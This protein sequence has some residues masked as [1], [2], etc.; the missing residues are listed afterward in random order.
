MN[1][2]ERQSIRDRASRR[3]GKFAT[4]ENS[5]IQ[6]ALDQDPISRKAEREKILSE[7][8]THGLRDWSSDQVLEVIRSIP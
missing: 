6:G 1:E 5:Y 4:L 7:I 8:E 3:P 2:E